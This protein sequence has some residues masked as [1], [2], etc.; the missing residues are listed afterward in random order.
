MLPVMAQ[1]TI[2]QADYIHI[3]A[4]NAALLVLP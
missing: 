1:Y 3:E 4:L 2:C